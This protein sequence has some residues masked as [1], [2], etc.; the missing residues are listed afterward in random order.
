MT[1]TSNFSLYGIGVSGGIAIG[2]T[3]LVSHATLDV[4]QYQIDPAHITDEVNR[5]DLAIAGVR[6][7][8]RA[9]RDEMATS[10]LA[11]DIEAFI[12]IQETLLNDDALSE[13]TKAYIVEHGCNAEWALVQQMDAWLAQFDQIEDEYLRERKFDIMQVVERVL[14][15]LTGHVGVAAPDV[16]VESHTILVAH[17]LSPADV[18]QYKYHRFAAFVTDLGG[19]TS[20]TAI[21]ARSLGVPALSGLRLARQL[22]REG[23]M[24]IVDGDSGSIIVNPSRAVLAQYRE[25]YQQQKERR[26][27]LMSLVRRRPKTKDGVETSLFINIEMPDNFTAAQK[28]GAQGIGLFRTE[29]LYLNREELPDERTQFLAYRRV[30]RGMKGKPVIL[31]TL[32]LGADKIHAGIDSLAR[33]MPNPAL[34]LRAIRLCFAEQALFTTQLRAILRASVFGNLKM[35]IPLLSSAEEIRQA[36]DIIDGVKKTLDEEGVA[37]DRNIDIG[38]MIEVPSAAIA[39]EPFLKR[40]SFLSI[41][42][43]DLV[44]YLLAVDRSDQ[45]VSRLYD[46]VHP[47]MLRLLSHVLKHAEKAKI[48]VSMCGEMAGDPEMTRLLLGLGLRHFSM[49]ASTLLAVKERILNTDLGAQKKS[50]ARILRSNSSLKTRALIEQLNQS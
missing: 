7:E 43:N 36:L 26:E 11:D 50:I 42:T 21:V 24:V 19:A 13:N 48:P 32:D 25:R 37:Y 34:G 40:F 18:L 39:I 31:R 28:V 44:Q 41:G 33:V 27:A 30:V 9:L 17:D 38:A 12:D 29:F 22:I 3:K 14:K 1:T 46:P 16:G 10:E 8:L 15:Q 2:R 20:H 45:A 4:S 47:A 35:M 5:L 6:N 23:E 49:S